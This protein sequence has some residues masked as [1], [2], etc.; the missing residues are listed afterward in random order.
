MLMIGIADLWLCQTLE[1]R[2]GHQGIKAQLVTVALRKAERLSGTTFYD[3]VGPGPVVLW[4]AI[5]KNTTLHSASL[6]SSSPLL[7]RAKGALAARLSFFNSH[8]RS[9]PTYSFIG[10]GEQVV[11]LLIVIFGLTASWIAEI[12]YDLF[13]EVSK[14]EGCAD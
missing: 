13:A 14:D 11:S 10:S 4:E 5:D 1:V 2:V 6:E 3:Y 7:P 9:N 8:S 12:K